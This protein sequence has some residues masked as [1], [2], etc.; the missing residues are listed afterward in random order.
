MGPPT[1]ATL[2]RAESLFQQALRLAPGLAQARV[3]LADV[4]LARHAS[5]YL[6]GPAKRLGN[7]AE[8]DSPEI[9]RIGGEAEAALAQDPSLA[10]A[11]ASIGLARSYAWDTPGALRAFHRAIELN[12]NYASAHLWLGRAYL[13]DGRMTDALA[14]MA[15]ATELDPLSPIILD[16][17]G[18][19]LVFAG[20]PAEALPVV[21]RALLI[22]P[23]H[24]QTLAW[25]TWALTDLGRKNESLK[26]A[27]GFSELTPADGNDNLAFAVPYALRQA[28]E[29]EAANAFAEK[30]S[31]FQRFVATAGNGQPFDA[32][33]FLDPPLFNNLLTHYLLFLPALDPVRGDPGFRSALGTLGLAEAHA[34]AQAWRAANPP[35]KPVT[36]R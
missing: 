16:N 15:R 35:T 21:E 3:G 34:R 7:F 19:A 36:A 1:P 12:P 27:R 31:G 6:L 14:A 30:L 33:P 17:Y 10:E 20:R 13:R 18:M 8:R 32:L 28:G 25:K 5:E 22:R 24:R 29:N 4:W 11:H 9:T 26:L 23:D 2:D